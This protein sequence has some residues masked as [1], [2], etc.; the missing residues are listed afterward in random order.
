MCVKI[1]FMNILFI[2]VAI[3]IVFLQVYR[4]HIR[5]NAKHKYTYAFAYASIVI[6]INSAFSC[7]LGYH[8]WFS[9]SSMLGF[10]FA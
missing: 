10:L 3:M 9:V 7:F 5:T 8:D 1:Y 2:V 6:Y 4:M